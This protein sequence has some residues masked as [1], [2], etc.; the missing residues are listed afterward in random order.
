MSRC[1][2]FL[3]PNYIFLNDLSLCWVRLTVGDHQ[4]LPQ[5]SPLSLFIHT[6]TSGQICICRNG[7]FCILEIFIFI[8]RQASLQRKPKAHGY[9]TKSAKSLFDLRLRSIINIYMTN[10][11]TKNIKKGYDDF[12]LHFLNV[13]FDLVLV[14]EINYH[15]VGF[16]SFHF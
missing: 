15:A 10:L 9:K 4:D 14:L 11:C 12:F 1:K 16:S 2:I 3:R 13:K 5:A 6:G 7:H 8:D